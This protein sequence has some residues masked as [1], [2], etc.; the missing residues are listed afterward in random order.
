[1]RIE[2]AWEIDLKGKLNVGGS[3][4]SYILTLYE[5][6]RLIQKTFEECFLDVSDHKTVMNDHDVATSGHKIHCS[7]NNPF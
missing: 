7:I 2:Q 4:N 6:S 3:I 1:M 5:T